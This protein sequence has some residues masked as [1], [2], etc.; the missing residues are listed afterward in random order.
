MKLIV[1]LGN[2]GS[3]YTNTRHN[4]GFMVID[5]LASKLSIKLDK[6]K[7]GGIYGIGFL[8]Q[9]KIMLLKPLLYV[10]LSGQVIRKFVDYFQITYN[11]ILVINDDL[12]LNMGVIKLKQQGGSGGHKGLENIEC[13]LKTK[14]Y[15]RLKIGIGKNK[16]IEASKYVTG[17]F[18]EEE[19]PSLLEA[20]DKA[21]KIAKDFCVMNFIDL[22]NKYN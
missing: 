9:Q 15:Q 5:K 21:S 3:E 22:M 18:T 7:F 13:C 14:E 10:N 17:K 2:V 1:G 12:D 6:K 19:E 11:H 20:V 4:L 16:N 8:N